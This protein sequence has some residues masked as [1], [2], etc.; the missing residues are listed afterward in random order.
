MH[1]LKIMKN[2]E[3]IIKT[4][5]TATQDQ[6]KLNIFL[7]CLDNRT[8]WIISRFLYSFIEINTVLLNEKISDV[9]HMQNI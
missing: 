7:S 4:K 2:N 5:K 1:Y 8:L 3:M 9:S 6:V